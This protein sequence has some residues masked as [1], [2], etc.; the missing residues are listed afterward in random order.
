MFICWSVI[1]NFILL[2]NKCKLCNRFCIAI[3]PMF[4]NVCVTGETLLGKVRKVDTELF[5]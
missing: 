5:K 1:T 3:S 4:C 2:S